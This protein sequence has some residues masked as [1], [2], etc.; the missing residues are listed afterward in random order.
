MSVTTYDP[1]GTLTAGNLKVT[2]LPTALTDLS[3]PSAAVLAAGIDIQ[4]ALENF[5]TSTDVGTATRR[6]LCDT[7]ET[8][9]IA[10]RTRKLENLTITGDKTSEAAVLAIL[11]EGA[12]IGIA[13]RPY[14]THDG[15]WAA[16]DRAWTFNATV[17]A[18][19]PAPV[20]TTDG[21]EF[22]YVVQFLDVTRDITAVA[23]A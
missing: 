10:K 23:V 21:E 12:K 15:A 2:L 7:E 16:G 6:K 8:E 5:G 1:A 17:A 20:S 9:R 22:G 3:A 4:C 11:T 19:D 18:V 14:D 13:A